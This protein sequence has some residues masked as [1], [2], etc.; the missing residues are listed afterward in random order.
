[1]GEEKVLGFKA[2]PPMVILVDQVTKKGG[3]A[4]VSEMMRDAVRRLAL[5]YGI[6]GGGDA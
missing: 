1:M 6:N 3:Y 4:S 5:H 2:T